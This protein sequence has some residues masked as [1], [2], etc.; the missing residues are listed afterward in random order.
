MGLLSG[1]AEAS[2]GGAPIGGGTHPPHSGIVRV[3]KGSLCFQPG[4]SGGSFGFGSWSLALVLWVSVFLLLG[5]LVG[6]LAPLDLVGFRSC[7]LLAGPLGP[8]SWDL[9]G[10]CVTHWVLWDCSLPFG[11]QQ[12]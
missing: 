4:L 5:F 10:P 8:P 12:F 9:L 3:W 6:V 1:L 11:L 7:R 2:I